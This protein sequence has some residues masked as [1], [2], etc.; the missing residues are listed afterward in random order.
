MRF[1]NVKASLVIPIS[2]VLACIGWCKDV[3][4]QRKPRRQIVSRHRRWCRR[5]TQGDEALGGGGARDAHVAAVD[6]RVGRAARGREDL[7]AE[8]VLE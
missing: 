6:G 8:Y 5:C 4:D 1:V 3:S 2:Q 7:L